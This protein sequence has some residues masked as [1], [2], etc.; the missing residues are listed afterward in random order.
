MLLCY[1]YYNGITDEKKDI[2]FAIEPKSFSIG[3]I[4]LLE[5]I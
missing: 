2:I 3:T 1:N 5:I 4:N